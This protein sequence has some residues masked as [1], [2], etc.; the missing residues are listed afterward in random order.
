VDSI[1]NKTKLVVPT[2]ETMRVYRAKQGTRGLPEEN[3]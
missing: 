3:V 2:K 1:S